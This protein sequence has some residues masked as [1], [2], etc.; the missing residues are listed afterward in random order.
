M[1]LPW[2][3]GIFYFVSLAEGHLS[4]AGGNYSAVFFPLIMFFSFPPLQVILDPAF[5]GDITIILTT[6][7]RSTDRIFLLPISCL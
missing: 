6:D 2:V 4:L 1:L 7:A 3:R 5:I